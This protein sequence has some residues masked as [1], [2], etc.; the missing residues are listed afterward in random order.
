M[1]SEKRLKR[2]GLAE[3][4]EAELLPA[5]EREQA[6]SLRRSQEAHQ[7][8]REQNPERAAAYDRRVAELRA[9]P[10]S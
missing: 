6:E 9:R 8:W 1:S 4:P 7:Q 5:L 2:L 10:M 3:T